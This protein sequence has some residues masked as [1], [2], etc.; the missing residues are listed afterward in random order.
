MESFFAALKEWPQGTALLVAGY[1]N[2]TLSDPE[3]DGRGTE[4][5][6]ALAE[7][8]LQDMTVQFLP[9]QRRWGR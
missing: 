1:L 3:N 2:T 4:I 6:M 7:A 9:R 5:V 8:V